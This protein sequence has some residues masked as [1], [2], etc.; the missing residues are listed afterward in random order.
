MPE[1]KRD[2]HWEGLRD[3]WILGGY[4]CVLDSVRDPV[5]STRV[6]GDQGSTDI[7]NSGFHCTCMCARTHMNTYIHTP[8]HGGAHSL[9]PK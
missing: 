9:F 1:W 5:S 3:V 8:I 6:G 7:I 2:R 4:W